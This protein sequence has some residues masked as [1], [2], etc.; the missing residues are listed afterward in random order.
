MIVFFSVS[1]YFILFLLTKI[2][3][4]KVLVILKKIYEIEDKKL[5]LTDHFIKF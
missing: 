3:C 1:F 4:I 5:E 2:V